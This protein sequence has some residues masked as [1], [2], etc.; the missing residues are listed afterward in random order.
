MSPKLMDSIITQLGDSI[1]GADD[2][3]Y[4]QHLQVSIQ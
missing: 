4:A 1:E 2:R 3:S